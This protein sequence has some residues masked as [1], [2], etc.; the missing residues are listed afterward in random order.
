MMHLLML[1]QTS[2]LRKNFVALFAIEG[3]FS[4]VGVHVSVSVVFACEHFATEIAF[5]GG[6]Q[7]IL[8]LT[9]KVTMEGKC[10]WALITYKGFFHRVRV[11]MLRNCATFRSATPATNIAIKFFNASPTLW[12]AGTDFM[13]VFVIIIQWK[14]RRRTSGGQAEALP[15]SGRFQITH[16]FR[17]LFQL[18]VQH[19]T[20]ILLLLLIWRQCDVVT[21][22]IGQFSS[23]VYKL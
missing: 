5:M 7:I 1:D 23:V 18:L 9:A 13:R 14:R 10:H 16:W 6:R 12:R 8:S 22:A 21:V 11:N 20:A 2:W 17:I 19:S 15:F 3:F 4:R